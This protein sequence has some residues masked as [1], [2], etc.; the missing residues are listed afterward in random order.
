MFEYFENFPY[1]GLSSH[2][3]ADV[4]YDLS[5]FSMKRR[6][7]LAYD[8]PG[9]IGIRSVRNAEV[10]ASGS[11]ETARGIRSGPLAFLAR[12]GSG[13]MLYASYDNSA[14]GEFRRFGIYRIAGARLMEDLEDVAAKWGQRVTGRIVN[15]VHGGE[16]AAMHRIDLAGGANYIYF[17]SDREYFQIDVVDRNLSLIESRD[18]LERDQTY[19]VDSSGEDHCYI[20]LYPST[21]DRFGMYA[22]VSASGRRTV[23]Y[24]YYILA[25]L[26]VIAAAGAGYFL[27]RHYI[28][29]G[30]RGRWRG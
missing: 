18:L 12:R 15:A 23:P 22:V 17:H 4:R 16:F 8:Q 6:M 20:R 30:Y 7:A 10:I 21:N 26:G 19:I 14:P 2:V 1:M 25:A 11:F 13:E 5:R 9:W 24:R 3:E 29:T 28:S 27:Y